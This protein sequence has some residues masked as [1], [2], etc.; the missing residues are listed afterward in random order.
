MVP[1]GGWNLSPTPQERG[2]Y[3]AS[4][5]SLNGVP[6]LRPRSLEIPAL[7]R[8]KRRAA[9]ARNCID[10]ALGQGFFAFRVHREVEL[11]FLCK[12]SPSSS[13]HSV[14]V[15]FFAFLAFFRG[16][17]VSSVFSCRNLLFSSAK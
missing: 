12:L 2:V 15:P 10:T 13:T 5:T 17:H 6:V 1:G 7:K 4:I 14:F 16:S 8:R 11:P 9:S 3:A